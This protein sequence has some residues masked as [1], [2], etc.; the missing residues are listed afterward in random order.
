MLKLLL[1]ILEAIK[2]S[3]VVFPL[4]EGPRIAVEVPDRKSQLM[5]LRSILL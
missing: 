4:P 2:L 5:S 1:F 3:R